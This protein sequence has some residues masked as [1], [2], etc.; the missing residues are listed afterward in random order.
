MAG[1]SNLKPG[2]AEELEVI[3]DKLKLDISADIEKAFAN[4]NMKN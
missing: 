4:S 3:L 1:V 2:S